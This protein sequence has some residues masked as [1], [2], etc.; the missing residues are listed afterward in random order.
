MVPK[1]APEEPRKL[2]FA[3]PSPWNTLPREVHMDLGR[4]QINNGETGES[5]VDGHDQP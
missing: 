2:N 1:R 4:T 3:R 5:P